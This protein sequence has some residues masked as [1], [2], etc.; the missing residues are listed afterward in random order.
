MPRNER[1]NEPIEMNNV[2]PL[3]F[4]SFCPDPDLSRDMMAEIEERLLG[5]TSPHA[6]TLGGLWELVDFA[7]ERPPE[8]TP[9]PKIKKIKKLDKPLAIAFRTGENEWKRLNTKTIP[10][11]PL[12]IFARLVFE[13]SIE[14]S[15]EPSIEN[16][17]T[18]RMILAKC[19][20]C[21]EWIDYNSSEWG[22][23]RNNRCKTCSEAEYLPV[24]S[25][26]G[27]TIGQG[28][29]AG[30]KALD[31]DRS[32]GIELEMVMPEIHEGN[33]RYCCNCGEDDWHEDDDGD[34]Q[35][36]NCEHTQCSGCDDRSPSIADK[37]PDELPKGCEIKGDNSINPPD[38]FVGLEVVTPRLYGL[39]GEKYVRNLIDALKTNKAEVNTSCGYHLHLGV[40]LKNW[41]FLRNLLAFYSVFDDIL[42]A[43]LPASRRGNKYCRAIKNHLTLDDLEKIHEAEEL[44]AFW[45]QIKVMSGKEK[46]RLARI[47]GEKYHETRYLGVNLHSAYYRGTVEIRYHSG[48]LS[49]QKILNWLTLNQSIFRFVEDKMEF[50]SARGW[51]M[52]LNQNKKRQL[53]LDLIEAPDWLRSYVISR[54]KELN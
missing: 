16:A 2:D 20:N 24:H 40:D 48:T 50:E 36:A 39:E 49:K 7:L 8:N 33:A 19:R 5:M 27:L 32:F 30:T 14:P 38:D 22:D 15:I 42:L 3:V 18:A 37:L 34:L 1:R 29:G 26:D 44:D 46:E 11:Q 25:Y 35:C 45:Y 23:G 47:K 41:Q 31:P 21:L 28:S 4:R 12:D 54:T 51:S 13:Q 9:F 52:V 17:P 6:E 10:D 53:F 43:M